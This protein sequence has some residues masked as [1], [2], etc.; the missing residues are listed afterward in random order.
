MTLFSV[1]QQ[2]TIINVIPLNKSKNFKFMSEYIDN[3]L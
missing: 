1:N 3:F 2:L